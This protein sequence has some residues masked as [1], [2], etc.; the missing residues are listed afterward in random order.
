LYLSVS[1]PSIP[2][3]T[4]DDAFKLRIIDLKL[5]ANESEKLF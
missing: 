4:I 5:V 3:T 1:H 2:L